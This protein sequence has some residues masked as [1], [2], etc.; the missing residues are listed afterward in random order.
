MRPFGSSFAVTCQGSSFQLGYLSRLQLTVKTSVHTC[1]TV[2]HQSPGKYYWKPVWVS[3]GI[4][5][6]TWMPRRNIRLVDTFAEYFSQ[7]LLA[8]IDDT[9]P[10]L[11][12]ESGALTSTKSEPCCI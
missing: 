7:D 12:R 5:P 6:N 9:T 1:C 3:G 2:C 11:E 10:G 8:N 4:Y